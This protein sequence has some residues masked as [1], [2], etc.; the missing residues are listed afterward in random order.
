MP[1]VYNFNESGE[2]IHTMEVNPKGWKG[3]LII[4]YVVCQ[5]HKYD[6]VLSVAWRVK[7]TT[8]TFTIGEQRLNVLSD[9]KSYKDHF[10][11]VL[12]RFRIDYLSWFKDKDYDNADWKYEYERQF[13]KFILPE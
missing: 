3:P 6:V 1:F 5:A 4:E 11:L 13:G 12:E 2:E 10:E 8:H 9:G 7:G